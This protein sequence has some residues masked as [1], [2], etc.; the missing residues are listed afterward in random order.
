MGTRCELERLRLCLLVCRGERRVP[1]FLSGE[2]GSRPLWRAA[3]VVAS[4]LGGAGDF[5]VAVRTAGVAGRT[6]YEDYV[7]T[8]PAA[9]CRWASA[10]SP[11]GNELDSVERELLRHRGRKVFEL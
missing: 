9:V 5:F 2:A 1:H 3:A 4:G 8:I 11:T 7:T 10:S 6:T